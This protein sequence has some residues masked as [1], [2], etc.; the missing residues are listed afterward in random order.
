MKYFSISIILALTVCS[1]QSPDNKN[2]PEQVK[3][4]SEEV[5]QTYIPDKRVGVFDIGLNVSDKNIVL[6][7]QTTSAQA[8]SLLKEKLT[9]ADYQV[10]DSISVLPDRNKLDNEIYGIVNL[11]VANLHNKA[12]FS[13]EMVTQAVL[14]MP[15]HILDYENWYRIQT[16]DNYIAWVHRAGIEPMTLEEYNAWNAS[17]KIV[18]TNHYGFAYKNIDKKTQ[19][20]FEVVS[21]VVA[22]NRFQYN[23]EEGNYYKVIYPDGR[24]GYVSKLI[25]KK[26]KDWRIDLKQDATSIL[27]TAYTL[28][29]VPYLWAGTS[30]KGM[31]CSG[32]VRNVLYMHDI[33]IP[34]DASQQAYVGKRIEI[35]QDFG[36]L[37]AGDLIFFGRKATAESK[38]RVV[39]VGIYIGDKKFIH[40]QGDVRIGSFDK[41]DVAFDEFNLNRLLFATRILD[42][43]NKEPEINTTL[44][45]PY[46]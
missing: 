43:V 10:T 42:V 32:F 3:Q 17:E 9:Q 44:T 24:K 1:C 46:Y 14:G 19:T 5:R 16:P 34:R 31:D 36:N 8:L 33:I 21:D 11:S 37:M 18:V 45:N 6:K 27:N 22:G 38:E 23:G 12:D 29:G 2:I 35:N 13:S 25:A 39:H 4:I 15:V 20:A 7:G 26:E 28:M 40:S 30:S 41:D